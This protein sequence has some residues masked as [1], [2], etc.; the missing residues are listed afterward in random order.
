MPD[1]LIRTDPR[2]RRCLDIAQRERRNAFLFLFRA[3]VRW[4]KAALVRWRRHRTR[5]RWIAALEDLD[6]RTLRDIGIRRAGIRTA[7][8]EAEARCAAAEM[9]ADMERRPCGCLRNPRDAV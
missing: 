5:R 2:F 1:L 7:V 3:A 6:D 9:R 4:S 8:R